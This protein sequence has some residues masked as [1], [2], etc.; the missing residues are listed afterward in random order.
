MLNRL[1]TGWSYQA[2]SRFHRRFAKLFRGRPG[3]ALGGLWH[4][5]FVGRT[6]LAPLGP[7][8]FWLDW[9]LT[10]SFLGHESEIVQT[11]E[12]LL[13]S[14][15]TPACVLD[16]G[17]NYG[18]HSL[19]FLAHGVRCVSFEPNPNCHPVLW[20]LADANRLEARL[21]P[22]ALGSSPGDCELWF[23]ETETWL[24]TTSEQ[25]RS[26]LALEHALQSVEVKRTTLDLYCAAH[27]LNPDLIK[28]DT[29]GNEL[30]VLEGGRRVLTEHRPLIIFECWRGPQRESLRQ[31]FEHVGYQLAALPLWD[32]DA[33]PILD[34]DAFI[35]SE[36]SNF[37]AIARV[38]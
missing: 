2:K 22:L 18:L 4:I 5:D 29:E 32:L 21:E 15:S 36:A 10:L 37:A 11:Y 6:L 25:V 19:L 38:D 30:E 16:V 26:E 31:F 20:R 1:Y 7:E 9:D 3:P 33:P 27:H 28:I 14:R 12:N 17:A 8:S 34:N 13:R 24:G 23:P 35:T